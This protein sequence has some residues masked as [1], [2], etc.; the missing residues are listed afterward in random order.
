MAKKLES[1]II[2]PSLIRD[3]WLSPELAV[4]TVLSFERRFGRKHLELACHAALPSILTPELIN[5]I[6]INFLNDRE[7]DWIAE[8]DFLLSPLCRPIEDEVYEVEPC[9]REVL[10]LEMETLYGEERTEEIKKEIAKF[11]WVYLHQK[12]Q[13]KQRPEFR[14][15]QEWIARAYLDPDGL[16]QKMRESLQSSFAEENALLQL[17]KQI[18]VVKN[19]ELLAEPLAKVQQKGDYQQLMRDTRVVAHVL[20]GEEQITEIEKGTLLLSSPFFGWLKQSKKTTTQLSK[21]QHKEPVVQPPPQPPIPA[22]LERHF[23]FLQVIRAITEGDIVAFLGSE[24]NLCDRP[25]QDNGEPEKWHPDCEFPPTDSEVAAYLIESA[26]LEAEAEFLEMTFQRGREDLPSQLLTGEAHKMFRL[27]LPQVA[28]DMELRYPIKGALNQIY[29]TNYHPNL[30]HKFLARLPAIMRSK[31]YFPSTLLVT[32]CYDRT[33]ELAFQMA[34]QPFDLVFYRGSEQKFVHVRF[35]HEDYDENAPIVQSLAQRIIKANEYHEILLNERP[36]ILKLYSS[37]N[38]NEENGANFVLTEDQFLNYLHGTNIEHILPPNLVRKLRRDSIWFLGCSPNDLKIK[39]SLNRIFPQDRG[40]RDRSCFAIQSNPS[41]LDETIWR[42]KEVEL[43]KFPLSDYV[44]E[45]EKQVMELPVQPESKPKPTIRQKHRVRATITWIHLSDWHEGEGSEYFDKQVVRDALIA[46][47]SEREQISPDL[48]KIDF[49]IFSGDVTFSGQEEEY[50]AAKKNLFEPLMAATRLIPERLF[51]VPGNHDLD[52]NVL[53]LL[54]ETILKPFE[55]EAQVVEWL[56]NDNKRNR[57]L[58]PFSAYREFVTQY[59]GREHPDYASIRRLEINGKRVALLG[60]NSAWMSS[61]LKDKS[62]MIGDYGRLIV[63]EPQIYNALHEIK[64]DDVRIVVL[65][66]PFDWLAEFDRDRIERLLR[67]NCHFIL[68]SHLHSSS[69]SKMLQAQGGDCVMISAGASYDRRESSNGYNFV[70]LDFETGQGTV[71]FRRW[72]DRRQQWIQDIESSETG[73]YEFRLPKELLPGQPKRKREVARSK[74]QPQIDLLQEP[75]YKGLM[76]Y[77]E[78]SALFF[79]GRK[80]EREIII[81]NLMVSRLTILYGASGVGKS[82]ILRAGVA[83][84]LRQIAK[85]NLEERGTPEFVVVVFNSWYNDPIVGLMQQIDAEI[86]RI[87]PDSQ[88]PD[89]G[90]SFVESLGIWTEIVGG[91]E[92][93]GQLFIIL[94]QFEEYFLYHPREEG[95]GTFAVE[96]PHAVNQPDLSVNFLI[97]IR[98]DALAKLDRFKGRIPSIF[99]NYLRIGHL[100]LQSARDAIVKPIEEYNQLRGT[101]ISI[102][103]E[104]VQEILAQVSIGTL[105]ADTETTEHPQIDIETP[106]LQMLMLRLWE[107]EMKIG[108]DCLRLETFKRLGEAENIVKQHLNERMKFLSGEEKKIAAQVFQYLVTPG[109]TKIAYPVLELAEKGKVKKQRLEDL[110]EKLSSSEQ[111]IVRSVG[112]SPEEPDVERYEIFHDVLAGPI[113]D[114]TRQFSKAQQEGPWK[115]FGKRRQSK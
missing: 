45:L 85:Q 79:F 104:L 24:I 41:D 48:K 40:H 6:R 47:I 25:L 35:D 44:T 60:L 14:K 19:L 82:S 74:E 11:L 9:V 31:G 106:Y 33:L 56:T 46:D 103:P 13:E 5:L 69:Q 95:E 102:E 62:G 112:P 59:T 57:L 80:R 109:G 114:W 98:D 30:L 77:S 4:R 87:L 113:L 81:D 91:E 110:L 53:E 108:S 93:R 12:T 86:K 71:Y 70:H 10:L 22:D 58:E 63:G 8:M 28:R 15:T 7:I 83:Y 100:D 18:P 84:H 3:Q 68:R 49:I 42:S 39:V 88:S 65:H 52:R 107:E 29:N 51:I 89:T 50:E 72:S 54:P 27:N 92:G 36:V 73:Q 34:R 76:P 37:T 17:S 97:S 16:I 21:T 75:P 23:H 1:I 115:L 96:F 99:G 111:R 61:R 101:S 2:N 64:N 105:L 20:Y 32:T 90:L 94:D 26:G 43:I 78:A 38:W 66:H 67:E 55:S